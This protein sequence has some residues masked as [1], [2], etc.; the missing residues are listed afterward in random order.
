MRQAR[1]VHQQIEIATLM[2]FTA[3]HGTKYAYIGRAMPGDNRMHY[4]TF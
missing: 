4:I 2:V 3:Q 1:R